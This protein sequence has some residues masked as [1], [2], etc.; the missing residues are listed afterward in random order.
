[1]QAKY[2][3]EINHCYML[4]QSSQ[5]FDENSYELKM[6]AANRIPALL[7]MT[8]SHID[9]SVVLQYDI[10]SLQ[11]LSVFCSSHKIHAKELTG[12]IGNLLDSLFLM[13]DYLLSEDHLFLDPEYLYLNWSTL[14]FKIAY[15]PYYSCDIKTSLQNLMQYLLTCL[16][17]EDQNTVVLA[18]RIYHELKEPNL[19]LG[20]I[21][22]L[23]ISDAPSFSENNPALSSCDASLEE[24]S[25]FPY[26]DGPDTSHNTEY[27]SGQ[28]GFLPKSESAP[29]CGRPSASSRS[30]MPDYETSSLHSGSS[31]TETK[32][33]K[34]KSLLPETDTW[35]T[36]L[37]GVPAAFLIYAVLHIYMLGYLT[38]IQSAA[39]VICIIAILILFLWLIRKRRQK[40][41]FSTSQHTDGASKPLSSGEQYNQTSRFIPKQEVPDTPPSKSASPFQ[42]ELSSDTDLPCQ[43]QIISNR[44]DRTSTSSLFA[45]FPEDERTVL[46]HSPDPAPDE[47]NPPGTLKL[48]PKDKEHHA[49]L[50]VID[51]DQDY[52]LLGFQPDIC[53]KVISDPTVSRIHARISRRDG[54]F[55]LSDLSSRNGTFADGTQLKVQEEVPLKKGMQL[56]FGGAEF[57][58]Q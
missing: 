54:I 47:S 39:A 31:Q 34:L 50:S 1:M 32:S 49:G 57:T 45:P 7:P 23:L 37:L 33:K 11:P 22:R 44:S 15:I 53:D 14:E 51:L 56:R 43:S 48:I 25:L 16:G 38:L 46:L 55:Y 20:N 12:L 30:S 41:S 40:D 5:P 18:Y 36:A 24:P 26:S 10:S 52:L 19:Q 6:I 21:R 58:V 4:F 9:D 8:C 35:K 29:F 42:S 3:R 13:E 17:N 28:S 2:I 27:S